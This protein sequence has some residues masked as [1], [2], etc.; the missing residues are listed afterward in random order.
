MHSDTRGSERTVH[1][2]MKAV[3]STPPIAH[4]SPHAHPYHSR[5]ARSPMMVV[6]SVGQ[7]YP[8]KLSPHSASRPP[9]VSTVQDGS[10]TCYFGLVVEQATDPRDSAVAPR[11]N[12]SPPSSSVKSF[13]AAIQNPFMPLDANPAYDAFRQQAEANHMGRMFA[14]SG[15][16]P[17]KSVAGTAQTGTDAARTPPIMRAKPLRSPG[18][19]L[20][21][22]WE[23][24]IPGSKLARLSVAPSAPSAPSSPMQ[25]DT[26]TR[27]ESVVFPNL[28]RH[29]SPAQ[30]ESATT[31]RTT[32][33][34]VEDRHPRL[35]LTM[36]RPSL[37]SMRGGAVA[38]ADSTPVK[39]VE[40]PGMMD[41]S[42]LKAIMESHDSAEPTSLLLLDVRVSTYYA[43]TRIR[44]ALNLCIPTTLLKRAT[45]NLKKLQLT[46]AQGEDQAKFATWPEAQYLV[47]YDSSSV[48][49][50][51]A[52][53][54]TNMLRK[55]TAE[56]YKGHAC[57]LRGGFAAFEAACP[58]L[59]D[60]QQATNASSGCSTL[61]LGAAGKKG[62]SIAPIIG[63]VML[64]SASISPVP[65]FQNIR[66]NM[67]LADGVGRLRIA[68]P[69]GLDTTVLPLWLREA[70][71]PT[72]QGNRVSNR[73][74][75]I[76]LAEQSRMKNAYSAFNTSVDVPGCTGK[77]QLSGI[78]KG[79]K[80]R[81]KDILPFEHARVRLHG[82]PEGAC[83]YVNASHIRAGRS[84][85]RYIASQGPL[86]ATFE[87][88]CL[89]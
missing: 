80:N 74:L 19:K 34:P 29:E 1:F 17:G 57:V 14:L 6:H 49:K 28:P 26:E 42:Q 52:T 43:A 22:S 35:S 78:E 40:G 84:L 9:S 44:G 83:D 55:F 51:D 82:R 30:L 50:R 58:Q 62:L 64:P 46:F 63:G 85:K 24:N 65:F 23:A 32:L 20:T 2:T 77:V 16:Q 31:T 33:S 86:P 56:G 12:W 73:F 11:D 38:R 4:S 72:D 76:E 68:V 53:S 37:T 75:R 10:G 67:D 8:P 3:R 88:G 45:Y 47:V 59:V 27:A 5:A 71:E 39:L 21:P 25:I 60:R 79:I 13:G 69:A 41:V 18:H 87:V 70:A 36:G 89:T 15:S 61:S 66:Q 7:P 81:Y 48:E 54:A